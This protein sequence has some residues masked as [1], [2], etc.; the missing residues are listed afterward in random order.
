MRLPVNELF[1]TL[2]GEAHFT[3]S[4]SVFIR[5]QGCDVGCPWCDTKHTWLTDPENEIS[6]EA[7]VAKTGDDA[8]YALVD[9][10]QLVAYAATKAKH[11]V[12]TGGEPCVFDLS[13]LTAQFIGAG[14]SVQ[15]ETSGTQPVRAHYGTWVTVSPKVDMPGR[16]KV[17]DTALLRANEIKMPVGK[18]A[19]ITKL[20]DIIDQMN[21][22]AGIDTSSPPLIWLQPLS[23]SLKATEL[24][25]EAATDHGWLVSIQTHKF[26]GLR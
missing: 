17:L 25:I 2:Q 12:I 7:M 20:Q 15:I 4:P 8:R 18:L 11:I 1:V 14:N 6:F 21:R 23:T 26:I 16:F 24:C 13:D 22:A 3:G 9:P 19:D 10:E 5:L